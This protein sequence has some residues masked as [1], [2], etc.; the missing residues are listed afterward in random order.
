MLGP[1]TVAGAAGAFVAFTLRASSVRNS[2]LGLTDSTPSMRA[3]ARGGMRSVSRRTSAAF[4][5]Q[6]CR[7]TVMASLRAA[8]CRRFACE[9]AA[10][11]WNCSGVA[12]LSCSGRSTT[13]STSPFALSTSPETATSAGSWRAS[14]SFGAGL[15]APPATPT[16]RPKQRRIPVSRSVCWYVM[17]LLLSDGS[18]C[19]LML[20]SRR[21]VRP[22]IQTQ[23][24]SEPRARM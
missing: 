23:M 18:A 7:S 17:G 21:W 6:N 16:R 9:R 15:C 24:L 10:R 11:V 14:E 13:S 19:I 22:D 5:S 4:V 2:L 20:R 8:N 3:S 12:A 1:S